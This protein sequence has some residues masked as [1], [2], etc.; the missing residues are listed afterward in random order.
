MCMSGLV[1]YT[2]IIIRSD[3][4]DHATEAVHVARHV[5]AKYRIL[6]NFQGTKFSR[7]GHFK[8]FRE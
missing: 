4:V 6:G 7:F 1:F 5:G 8:D 3:P 2:E